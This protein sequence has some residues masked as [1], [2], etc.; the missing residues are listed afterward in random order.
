MGDATLPAIRRWLSVIG[1]SV[2]TFVALSL[3][4]RVYP[5]ATFWGA[6]VALV[7]LILFFHHEGRRAANQRS[8]SD[9]SEASPR[10]AQPNATEGEGA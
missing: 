6:F 3:L 9:E 7:G 8:R 4:H 1:I 10:P 2:A 5:A